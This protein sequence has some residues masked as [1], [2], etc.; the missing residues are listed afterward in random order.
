MSKTDN[1]IDDTEV[2][3]EAAEQAPA[4]PNAD[5]KDEWGKDYPE[6]A[7]LFCAKFE[8]EDF[9]TEYGVSDYG[10]GT[11]VAVRRCPSKP[12]PGWI[13]RHKNMSDLERTFA[14]L[15]QHASDDAL[16]VLDSLTEDAWEKFVETWGIDGGLIEPGKSRKSS[17]RRAK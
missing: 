11:T 14:L 13:R 9:D 2:Q 1:K 10:D 12:T 16:D 7:E 6:G 15:E 8:A 17:R 4:D 3:A 5:I